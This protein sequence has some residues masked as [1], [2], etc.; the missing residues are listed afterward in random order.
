MIIPYPDYGNFMQFV[1]CVIMFFADAIMIYTAKLLKSCLKVKLF[2]PDKT[3]TTF[4][5]PLF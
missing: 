4:E 1:L 2:Y 5:I 3:L